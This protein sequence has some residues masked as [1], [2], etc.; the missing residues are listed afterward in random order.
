MLINARFGDFSRSKLY[1]SL[2]RQVVRNSYNFSSIFNTTKKTV[3]LFVSRRLILISHIGCPIS[4]LTTALALVAT[5]LGFLDAGDSRRV[6]C[7]K[8]R[9]NPP[10]SGNVTV[11]NSV[12][13]IQVIQ[14]SMYR[15]WNVHNKGRKREDQKTR[16]RLESRITGVTTA[17]VVRERPALPS[18]IPT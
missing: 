16:P 4:T 18:P 6:C 9:M 8:K 3:I 15:T 12:T 2:I 10:P 13:V 14:V 5:R 17:T 1:I 7:K 11:P